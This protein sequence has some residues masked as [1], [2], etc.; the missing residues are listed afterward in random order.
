VDEARDLL[1]E[2]A[3]Q[4]SLENPQCVQ[5]SAQTIASAQPVLLTVQPRFSF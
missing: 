5:L 3:A 1:G 4:A 2:S